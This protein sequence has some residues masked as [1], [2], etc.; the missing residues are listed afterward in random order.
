[1]CMGQICN[2]IYNMETYQQQLAAFQ[3]IIHVDSA[4]VV[5]TIASPPPLKVR[6]IAPTSRALREEAEFQKKLAEHVKNIFACFVKA[7]TSEEALKL[8]T[9]GFYPSLLESWVERNLSD[10]V[11][12]YNQQIDI[13]VFKYVWG[14]VLKNPQTSTINASDHPYNGFEIHMYATMHRDR[15]ENSKYP[16]KN[17]IHIVIKPSNNSGC[18][19]IL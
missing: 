14:Y 4:L 16:C 15:L 10:T 5:R 18:C 1:M 13:E 2:N 9:Y 3:H 11:H 6:F 8:N 19:V 12:G 7:F 17:V